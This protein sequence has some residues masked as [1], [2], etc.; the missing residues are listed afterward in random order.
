MEADSAYYNLRL[1]L[2]SGKAFS[3]RTTKWISS[4]IIRLGRFLKGSV[5]R[6][7]LARSLITRICLSISG[8]CSLTAVVFK[9]VPWI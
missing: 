7:A 8:A 9:I 3:H 5:L 1:S 6:M 2:N 4:I